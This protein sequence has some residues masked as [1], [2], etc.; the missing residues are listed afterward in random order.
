MLDNRYFCGLVVLMFSA[1]FSACGASGPKD[2]QNA[3]N[4]PKPADPQKLVVDTTS[5][6]KTTANETKSEPANEEIGGVEGGVVGGVV[7]GVPGGSIPSQNTPGNPNGPTSFG[8]GMTRPIQISGPPV[9]AGIKGQT[10]GLWV[11]R[12]IITE[13][14]AITEC[15]VIRS[16]P[17]IDAQLIRNLEAQKYSPVTYQGKPQRVYY[18][19]KII[20][21]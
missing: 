2:V 3:S 18:T 16:L 10:P 17:M 1:C 21:K 6:E 8:T 4:E 11:G 19:F 7:G 9:T 12:C 13:D 5:A 14:G 20:F 15:K